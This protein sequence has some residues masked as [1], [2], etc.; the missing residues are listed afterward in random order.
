MSLSLVR[1]NY[2]VHFRF[3]GT[4]LLEQVAH[5]GAHHRL[6]VP[7]RRS[8][9]LVSV[10][11]VELP[12]YPDAVLIHQSLSVGLHHLSVVLQSVPVERFSKT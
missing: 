6:I 9:Q 12:R 8:A 1:A 5:P 3:R 4:P 10:T 11:A 2:R 7:S